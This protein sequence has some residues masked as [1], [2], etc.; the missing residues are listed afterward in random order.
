VC[1][2]AV[3]FNPILPR[4]RLHGFVQWLPKHAAFVKSIAATAAVDEELGVCGEPWASQV[5]AAQQLLQQALQAAADATELGTAAAAAAAA[6]L[7]AAEEAPIAVPQQQQQPGWRLS[8]F[9]S[10]LPAAPAL[11]S[12][13]PARSLKSLSLELQGGTAATAASLG[14]TQLAL[15]TCLQQLRLESGNREY[16]YRVPDGC[17][18]GVEQMKRL[19]SLKVSGLWEGMRQQLEAL[20]VLPLPLQLQLL[21]LMVAKWPLTSQSQFRLPRIAHLTQ[22]TELIFQHNLPPGAALPPSLQRLDILQCPDLAPVLQLQQLQHLTLFAESGWHAATPAGALTKTPLLQLAQ[23]PALQTLALRYYGVEAA[24]ADVQTW[25]LLPQLRGLRLA[26]CSSTPNNWQVATC[27]SGAAAVTGLTGLQLDFW[28][29]S[30]TSAVAACATIAGLKALKQFELKGL[31]LV[32]GDVMFLTALTGLT[33]LDLYDV[34]LKQKSEGSGGEVATTALAQSSTQLR[35]LALQHCWIDLSSAKVLPAIGQ[36]RPLTAL[37][38]KGNM[39]LSEQGLMQLTG[40]TGLQ[41]LR[42]PQTRSSDAGVTRKVL[43]RFWAAV[44]AQ[45]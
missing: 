29:H 24:A 7:A 28:G 13:L 4:R 30:P 39:W 21:E 10:N 2:T 36:L 5:A 12:A 9:S 1:N 26:C 33:L 41:R 20:L 43:D 35:H 44:R 38:L 42:V 11:Q 45:R 40:L 16:I 32:H 23:L 37:L 34:N 31:H 14:L 27:L 25:P 17:L 15:L 22:L 8:G 3:I 6:G 18:S 19:T